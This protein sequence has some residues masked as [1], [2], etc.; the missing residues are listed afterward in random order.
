MTILSSPAGG[1]RALS[2]VI[3]VFLFLMGTSKLAW[4]ADSGYLTYQ[5]E[6]WVSFEPVRVSRWYLE[7][8][9]LPGAPLFARLV[10]L[11]ELATGAALIAGFRVRL[12]G[13]VALAMVVNFQFASG[14][15]F[16][17]GY[18]TNGY[19]PPVLG[20]LLALAIGGAQRLPYSARG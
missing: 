1:L 6:E 5:L 8:V 7:W 4:F 2:L 18:L 10:V 15:M 12:A 16:T 3:G 11:G 20:G 19:G 14:I 9:A 17:S 13:A